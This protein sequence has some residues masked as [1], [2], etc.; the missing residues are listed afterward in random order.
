MMTI[1]GVA[2]SGTS[3][4]GHQPWQIF[5]PRAVLLHSQR[6][7]KVTSKN[8]ACLSQHRLAH[9]HAVRIGEPTALTG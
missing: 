1:D 8:T 3:S 9:W 7:G 6:C 4:D 2:R 5:P